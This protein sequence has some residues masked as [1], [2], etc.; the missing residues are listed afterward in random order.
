MSL[1]E[2]EREAVET[3]AAADS[4]PSERVRRRYDD[5]IDLREYLLV[6]QARWRLIAA[7][8]LVATVATG[9]VT[10]FAMTKSYRAEAIIRPVSAGAV[11]SR[12]SGL[13]GGLGGLG[14]AAGFG[15]SLFGNEA[16]PANEYMPVLQSFDF[17]TQLIASHGLESHLRGPRRSLL[18]G[19]PPHPR[20]VRYRMMRSRFDC[21]FSIRTGN[22]T[23][24]Y[25][26]PDRAM[27]GKILG[28]YISDLRELLRHQE[29]HDTTEAIASLR[30]E[31]KD[32]ADNLL[33][34]QLSELLARQIQQQKLAQ[35]QADFAFKVLEPPTTPDKPYR[36]KVLL[37][38]VLAGVLTA[39]SFG[40]WA[41]SSSSRKGMGAT[42]E[43]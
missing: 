38:C 22:L 39:L 16:N 3:R 32:T 5:E 33:Q 31:I 34:T 14:G 30:D 11:E 15:A 42:L 10:K 7:A 37:D 13:I 19:D 35:V 21:E 43:D 4:A 40:V 2:D 12:L 18:G 17:T 26:D 6:L 41:L 9:V 1:A 8:T 24:Y 25:Q 27:A 20:W 36:P 28:Y 23:F 29:I